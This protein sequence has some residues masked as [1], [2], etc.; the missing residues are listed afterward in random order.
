MLH[1]SILWLPM[2]YLGWLVEQVFGGEDA[3]R[4]PPRLSDINPFIK[5]IE[6][7]QAVSDEKRQRAIAEASRLC[8]EMQSMRLLADPYKIKEY[9]QR[10]YEQQH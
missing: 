10:R 2:A 7:Q 8:R 3:K 9:M 6:E 5:E 4:P 1:T